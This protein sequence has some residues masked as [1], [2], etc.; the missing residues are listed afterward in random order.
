M[1]K[2][3]RESNKSDILIE[4]VIIGLVGNLALRNFSYSLEVVFM[5]E[6]KGSR[7]LTILT[8]KLFLTC[9]KHENK[10]HIILAYVKT[11]RNYSK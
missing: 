5:E 8:V 1:G 11:V 10:Y 3:K 7:W 2:G 4:G 6:N 9:A